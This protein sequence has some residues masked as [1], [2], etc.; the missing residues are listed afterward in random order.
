MKKALPCPFY[1]KILYFSIFLFLAV[2]IFRWLTGKGRVQEGAT[3]KTPYAT[4]PKFTYVP[5][6]IPDASIPTITFGLSDLDAE[7]E[8]AC[9]F[10]KIDSS[11]SYVDPSAIAT[12]GTDYSVSQSNLKINTLYNN[13]IGGGG[14]NA[15]AGISKAMDASYGTIFDPK[16]IQ[17]WSQQKIIQTWN[18]IHSVQV[19]D[20][21]YNAA[22]Y[23][24]VNSGTNANSCANMATDVS[25]NTL[26]NYFLQGIIANQYNSSGLLGLKNAYYAII[27]PR[28]LAN[29]ISNLYWENWQTL[30]NAD[31]DHHDSIAYV[32]NTMNGLVA[33]TTFPKDLSGTNT[34]DILSGS[35]TPFTMDALRLYQTSSVAYELYRYLMQFPKVSP[36]PIQTTPASF[37]TGF[38]QYLD[39]LNNVAVPSTLAFVLQNPPNMKN[40]G[41]PILS[42]SA[43]NLVY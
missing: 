13:S 43:T 5:N 26:G 19:D 20:A 37:A 3:P 21:I 24:V 14:A 34:Q 10:L 8:N 18:G 31:G 30:T 16:S 42:T 17:D 38:Q 36:N 12:S 9:S 29:T 2:L 6:G 25:A 22:N 35:T 27:K 28:F 33:N 32:V 39:T 40:C 4:N 41:T 1:I 11:L 7:F 23:F 15:K